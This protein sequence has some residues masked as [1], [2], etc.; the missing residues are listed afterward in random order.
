M[1]FPANSGQRYIKTILADA[2]GVAPRTF[3]LLD[4]FSI[5]S[6]LCGARQ[7][8]G[9]L[10]SCGFSGRRFCYTKTVRLTPPTPPRHQAQSN[11]ILLTIWGINAPELPQV[12]IH[13]DLARNRVAE[14]LLPGRPVLCQLTTSQPKK[15]WPLSH[16]ADFHRQATAVGGELVFC[17]G[18][19]PREQR[20]LDQFKKLEGAASVLPP[21]P[22]LATFLAVLK[23]ARLFISGD[24]GPLHL[25][26][27]LGVPTISLF[28]PSSIGLWAPLGPEHQALKGGVCSCSGNTAVCTSA[29]PCMAGISPEAVLRLVVEALEENVERGS[30]RSVERDG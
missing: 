28:G 11:F 12:E 24:T 20:L 22:E 19:A 25:A 27:G 16:W 18:P 9:P 8:V 13:A 10:R 21:V 30:V 4:S 1:G 7:R 3:R 6:L 29:N 2:P 15:E 23:R 17:A 26:A 5:V 14:E